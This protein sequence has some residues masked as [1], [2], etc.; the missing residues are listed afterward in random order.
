MLTQNDKEQILHLKSQEWTWKSIS[1][2][3]K[4]AP[5]ACRKFFQRHQATAWL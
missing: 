3:F 4:A 1:E 2:A 5:A